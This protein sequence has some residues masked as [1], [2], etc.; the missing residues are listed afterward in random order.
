MAKAIQ[1]VVVVLCLLCILAILIAPLAD[2]PATS[3]RSYQMAVILLWGLI[4]GALSIAFSGIK[5]FSLVWRAE[6]V[7]E[8]RRTNETPSLAESYCI[9]R[10]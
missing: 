10:C 2:L 3:L 9:L 6:R 5:Q 7:S 8:H 1:L 4:A